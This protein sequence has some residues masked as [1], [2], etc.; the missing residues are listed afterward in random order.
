M[1]GK[2]TKRTNTDMSIKAVE[3]EK[4]EAGGFEFTVTG[5]ASVKVAG[6]STGGSNSSVFSLKKD[7]VAVVP[8][9]GTDGVVVVAGTSATAIE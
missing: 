8:K 5:T 2:V 9:G 1:F 4:A 7:G 3:L 6:S